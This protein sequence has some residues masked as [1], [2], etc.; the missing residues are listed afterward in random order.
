MRRSL[1]L[2]V[3][4]LG[5]AGVASCLDLA[6]I[7]PNVCG[8]G[9]VEEGED[10]DTKA[11]RPGMDCSKSSEGCLCRKPGQLNECRW[12]CETAADCPKGENGQEEGWG[13]GTDQV[14]RRPSTCQ[15]WANQEACDSWQSGLIIAENATNLLIADFDGSGRDSLLSVAPPRVSIHYFDEVGRLSKTNAVIAPSAAPAVGDLTRD[16]SAGSGPSIAS[17]TI[18]ASHGIEVIRGSEDQ[19]LWPTVY[20]SLSI[21]H[22]A[23]VKPIVYKS[24]KSFTAP[25]LLVFPVD[26]AGRS[27]VVELLDS[28]TKTLGKLSSLVAE[29][30][31]AGEVLVA[32]LFPNRA[33]P[34]QPFAVAFEGGTEVTVYSPCRSDGSPNFDAPINPTFVK[35]TSIKL[36]LGAKVCG[37]KCQALHAVDVDKDGILDLV[38]GG[39]PLQ[40]N[41]SIFIAYNRGD[42]TFSSVRGPEGPVD[43]QASLY[44]TPPVLLPGTDEKQAYAPP[45]AVGDINDDCALDYVNG[46]GIYLSA[47]ATGRCAAPAGFLNLSSLDDEPVWTAARI[48]DLTGDGYLDVAVGSATAAGITLYRGTGT[49]DPLNPFK[50]VTSSGVRNFAIGDFDGDLQSDLA[51][52]QADDGDGSSSGGDALAIVFGSSTSGPS[53]PV[54]MGATGPIQQIVPTHVYEAS[55]D[56]ITDLFVLSEDWSTG[57]R[58]IALF[59]GSGDRQL[60]APFYLLQ[61]AKGMP[62]N[63]PER[64]V[65]GQFNG[66]RHNDIAVVAQGPN[67]RDAT[68][69][70]ELWLLPSIGEAEIIPLDGSKDNGSTPLRFAPSDDLHGGLLMASVNLG[71]TEEQGSDTDEVVL[72]VGGSPPSLYVASVM[73]DERFTVGP[74]IPLE[75]L[76]SD[77][78]RNMQVLVAD[79]DGDK[80]ADVVLSSAS[81]VLVLWNQGTGSVDM[82][83]A[84]F[85][86]A[87][88]IQGASCG[89]SVDTSAA[90]RGVGALN[91]DSDPEKELVIVTGTSGYIADSKDH[92]LVLSCWPHLQGGNVV[93]GGDLDGDGVDDIVVGR[94]GGIE[95]RFGLVEGAGPKVT[96]AA[97]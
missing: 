76:G 53:Q 70:R 65:I 19:M 78:I 82:Q 33:L 12:S 28:Q 62:P 87:D 71:P 81:G 45:L 91:V 80:R 69:T 55:I 9:F 73:G 67:C 1:W 61:S 26:D 66:D 23:Q 75:S 41:G 8:N 5:G 21:P 58:N 25:M 42:G 56:S 59:P 68:C 46:F 34:C 85:R 24:I 44:P 31:I 39:A 88:D 22:A 35:P 47:G 6:P 95:V 63:F 38:I 89:M 57:G 84:V 4:L 51:F 96:T 7:A 17:F 79:V 86:S 2:P 16:D 20:A 10:C 90:V 15:P 14:C 32:D 13:C 49:D 30:A 94:T 36:P 92:E 48:A 40:S 18:N 77:Q 74:S 43:N 54:V 27:S 50:L 83:H 11:S 64:S 97:P 72:V 52:S 93:V 60:R 37:D 29:G 3:F